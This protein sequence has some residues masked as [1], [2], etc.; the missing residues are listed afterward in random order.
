MNKPLITIITACF[1]SAATIRGTIESVLNQTYN[2]IEY[3]IVDGKSTDSTVE[4]IK[5]FEQMF[6]EKRISF[7]HVSEKDC[8]IYDAWNKGIKMANGDWICF[9]GS[10]DKLCMNAM[11]SYEKVIV[12]NKNLEYISSKVKLVKNNKIIKILSGKW[13]WKIFKRYMNVAHVGSLHSMTYF[14]KYG[15]YNTDFNIAGDYELLLRSKE[16]L[17]YYFLN[18]VTAE[19][20]AGGISNNQVYKALLETKYAKINTAD[21]NKYI[22]NIYFYWALLKAKLKRTYSWKE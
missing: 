11:K 2:N 21:S 10:D 17:K 15:L 18:E 20:D 16:N 6:K 7:K 5:R 12:N 14:K 22:A 3:I 1:N 9:L 8:G 13:K 19:M 4:I